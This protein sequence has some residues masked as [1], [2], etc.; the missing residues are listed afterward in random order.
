VLACAGGDVPLAD[1]W[2]ARPNRF[3]EK[4]E[5]DFGGLPGCEEAEAAFVRDRLDR[6]LGYTRAV[7][8]WAASRG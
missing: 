4:G 7:V 3:G 8:R 5:A 1:V 2:L 6:A